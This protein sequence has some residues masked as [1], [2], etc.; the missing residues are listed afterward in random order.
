MVAKSKAKPR[1]RL[2]PVRVLNEAESRAFIDARARERLGM[3]VDEFERKW[4]A[5]EFENPDQGDLIGI[6]ILLGLA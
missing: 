3:S 1:A 5:A 2:P 6:A 4:Q